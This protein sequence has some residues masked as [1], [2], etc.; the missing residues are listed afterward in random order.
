MQSSVSIAEQVVHPAA[1]LDDNTDSYYLTKLI[2]FVLLMLWLALSAAGYYLRSKTLVLV[3]D[4]FTTEFLMAALNISLA[5]PIFTFLLKGNGISLVALGL[6]TTA[7]FFLFLAYLQHYRQTMSVV[8]TPSNCVMELCKARSQPTRAAAVMANIGL[9]ICVGSALPI[10]FFCANAVIRR[11]I[12]VNVHDA[13]LVNADKFFLGWLFPEGQLSLFLDTS[14][15]LSPETTL[16]SLIG[17]FLSFVYVSYYFYGYFVI[18]ISAIIWIYYLANKGECRLT[19]KYWRACQHVA[20]TWTFS[21]MITFLLN[22]IVPARSPRLH[23]KDKFIHPLFVSKSST[24]GAPAK[25]SAFS[26]WLNK[27]IHQDDTYGSFPS[28][29]VGETLSVAIAAK[30]GGK[31]YQNKFLNFAGNVVMVISVFM[32]SA[33]LWLRYHYFVDVLVAILVA[34]G[35]EVLTENFHRIASFFCSQAVP[36][37]TK[38]PCYSPALIPNTSLTKTENT[39]KKFDEVNLSEVTSASAYSAATSFPTT[40]EDAAHEA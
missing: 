14:P 38:S 39:E 35:S 32:A 17:H 18:G 8:Q 1:P 10:Y 3:R 13:E 15:T 27:T 28:G 23:L 29:H 40:I 24:E 11:E 34:S 26:I 12:P 30:M 22:T 25:P 19:E 20:A 5:G 9:L 4:V 37:V 36:A 21:F 33:T 16:G 7:A 6:G 2:S 31:K